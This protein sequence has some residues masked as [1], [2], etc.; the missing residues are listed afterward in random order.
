MPQRI[1]I[2]VGIA[3]QPI[4][5]A[6]NTWYSLNWVLGFVELGWE[7]WIVESLGSD[8]TIDANWNSVPVAESENLRNWQVTVDR[9]GLAD[10]STLLID[11][12]AVNRAEFLEFANRADVFLNLSG[13]YP[14]H[15]GDFPNAI[16]IY[17]DADPAFTQ[18]WAASYRCDMNFAAHDRFVTV[19][20]RF[21][22]EGVFAPTCGMDWLPS[23]AP[24]VLSHWPFCPQESFN[25]FTTVAH[26]EGYKNAEWN[27]R[28]FEG[29]REEFCRFR[30]VPRQVPATMEIAMAVDAHKSELGRFHDAGWQFHEAKSVCSTFEA[31]AEYLADSSAEFSVAKSGYVVSNGGWVSDRSVCYAATGRPIVVQATGLETLLP[32]GEGYFAFRTPQEAVESCLAVINDFS[33]QQRLARKLAEE[34]FDSKVVIN[35]LLNR[36]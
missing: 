22:G 23:F 35:R 9:F 33:N 17:F 7:V 32:V 11:G 25:K 13:H 26:W 24:V 4:S 36:L 31:Y 18:I 14:L 1:V 2:A 19:G 8:G 12:D 16:K 29:K 15:E 5:A 6:G 20:T 27:S 3:A 28:W 21:G 30:D 34:F 10:R